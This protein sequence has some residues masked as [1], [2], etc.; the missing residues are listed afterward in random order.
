MP[1]P[2]PQKTCPPHV[3]T[4]KG[5]MPKPNWLL[6]LLFVDQLLSD[7]KIKIGAPLCLTSAACV[8]LWICNQ[9]M[10][11]HREKQPCKQGS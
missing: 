10:I 2:F 5:N 3:P 9:G 6:L 7:I 11:T 8:P 1:H 4:K